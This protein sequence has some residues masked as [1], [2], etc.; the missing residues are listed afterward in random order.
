MD[1]YGFSHVEMMLVGHNGFCLKLHGQHYERWFYADGH[2]KNKLYNENARDERRP[3]LAFRPG[4]VAQLNLT[5][6]RD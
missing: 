6:D 4:R 5:G 3:R 1:L 2:E